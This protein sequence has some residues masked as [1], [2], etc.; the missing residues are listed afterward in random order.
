GGRVGQWLPAELDG[1]R[2]ALDA[3]SRPDPPVPLRSLVAAR[4]GRKPPPAD[5]VKAVEKQVAISLAVP[6]PKPD[7]LQKALAEFAEKTAAQPLD[8][9]GLLWDKLLADAEPQALKV[10]EL[11]GLIDKVGPPACEEL[12]LLRRLAEWRPRSIEWPAAAVNALLRAEDAAGRALGLLPAGFPQ[13]GTALGAADDARR[14]GERW[15]FNASSQAEARDA[16]AALGRAEEQFTAAAR[17]LEAVR[18]ARQ[19]VADAAVG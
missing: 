17:V 3:A 7:D 12:L 14:T 2:G 8:A 15:L 5:L 18:D 16:A 9:A 11:A 13:T 4:L 10:R 19:A 6:P 1:L